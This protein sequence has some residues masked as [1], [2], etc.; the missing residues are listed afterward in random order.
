MLGLADNQKILCQKVN[1]LVDFS[2]KVMHLTKTTLYFLQIN[3]EEKEMGKESE[4]THSLYSFLV[5]D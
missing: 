2:M 4:T 1:T 3:K 5:D